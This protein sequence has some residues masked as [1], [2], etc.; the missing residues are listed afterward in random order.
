MFTHTDFKFD[1]IETKQINGKRHYIT[2]KG[3]FPSITTV[4]S[5]LSRKGIA[6]WRARV[7][8]E[9][10]N[11][12]S[13]MAARRGTNVHLMCEDYINNKLD[14]K[15]FMPNEREMFNSIKPILD[16]YIDNVVA[17][18]VPLW[19]SYLGIAGRVDCIAEYEG[20]LSVIDFK[21]SRK[22]KKR[23]WIGSYFQQASAYCVMFEERTKIPIDQIV[24]IIAVEDNKPEVYVEKR[25]N[26]IMECID[27]IEKYYKEQLR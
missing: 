16:E 13:T 6:E 23:E 4:L 26:H 14:D 1:E 15:K 7:G 17:Q 24:I 10:A 19:S 25:D 5:I 21:T 18:E 11:K 20:R 2:P 22:P 27:T 8:A 12:I 9:A 3:N